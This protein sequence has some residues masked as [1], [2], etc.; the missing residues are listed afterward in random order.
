M[1]KRQPVSN[2]YI[3]QSFIFSFSSINAS[4]VN[5]PESFVASILNELFRTVN[6]L[7]EDECGTNRHKI[8]KIDIKVLNVKSSCLPFDIF[9]YIPKM[10]VK[11]E[12]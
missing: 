3:H 8:N 12:K 11:Q 9:L 10:L 7:V 2:S 1:D 6:M 4:I 5:I